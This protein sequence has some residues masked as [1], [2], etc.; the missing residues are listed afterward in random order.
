LKFEKIVIA[1]EA[2]QS[3]PL[4]WRI[5]SGFTLAMTEKLYK[6]NMTK[7]HLLAPKQ[8]VREYAHRLA[9]KLA[10]EHFAAISD[11]ERQCQQSGTRYLPPEKAIV[12]EHLNRSYRIG[13]PGGEV[14]LAGS[15]EPVPIR[16]KI[17][18]LHYFT[19]ARGTP[20][21]NKIITYKELHEGINY[22]PTFFKRAIEPVVKNFKDEPQRLLEIASILG[23]R[24]V[25]YGDTAVR[26]DAFPR[27]PITIVLWLGDKEFAPDGNIM[28]DS[29]I[30]DYLPT[31]DITILC[32][33]IA[34]RLVRLL[35]TGGDH[36][37]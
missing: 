36:P 32:E 16:D 2:K 4:D 33:V 37:G 20:L 3:D 31:E 29:T 26:I 10:L 34:W 25:D 28:F 17:L 21:T 13:F 1:S 23:G 22:Y 6:A 7:E 27:V 15:D 11:I 8:S 18:I 30:P 14:T 24:K 9:L 19:R 5:A 12:L 35:K